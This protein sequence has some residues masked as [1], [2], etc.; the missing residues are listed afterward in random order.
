MP[1]RGDR[2]LDV[3]SEASVLDIPQA[4]AVFAQPAREF[5]DADYNLGY[6]RGGDVAFYS[7][8]VISEATVILPPF[9]FD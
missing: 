1:L 5:Y 2:R 8:A 7:P 4:H 9:V 6:S 3:L